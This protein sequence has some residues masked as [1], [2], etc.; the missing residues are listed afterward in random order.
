M[1]QQQVLKGFNQT[2]T[3]LVLG[4]PQPTTL[5]WIRRVKGVETSIDLTGGKYSGGSIVC[6][7]LTIKCI[8]KSDEGSYICKARNEAGEGCSNE[9][10]LSLFG[11]Y[12]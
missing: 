9:L 11:Q 1:E 12:C 8:D 4:R 10:H 6:P 5:S 2:L 3:C 7:S